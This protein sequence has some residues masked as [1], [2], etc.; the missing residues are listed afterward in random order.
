MESVVDMARV[1]S[2]EIQTGDQAFEQQFA[3]WAEAGDEARAWL[4]ADRRSTIAGLLSEEEYT[5]SR[6]E[7]CCQV[8]PPH[9][10]DSLTEVLERLE[11]AADA[12]E[13]V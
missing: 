7:V 4:D 13:G 8:P 9:S 2:G 6:G 1:V 11:L 3:V 10:P 5:V 12:L